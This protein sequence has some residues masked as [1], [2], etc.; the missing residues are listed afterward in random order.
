VVGGGEGGPIAWEV[1]SLN[2]AV[3]TPAGTFD[4]VAVIAYT[5]YRTTRIYLAHH[6]GPVQIERLRDRDGAR[7]DS[8]SWVLMDY[9]VD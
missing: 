3:V 9:G 1:V 7:V 6:V 2:T 4:D 8:R 5:G